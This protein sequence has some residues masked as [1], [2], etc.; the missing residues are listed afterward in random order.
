M[1]EAEKKPGGS[2][3]STAKSTGRKTPQSGR[4]SPGKKSTGKKT[5]TGKTPE[6][7]QEATD[8]NTQFN[9]TYYKV[10]VTRQHNLSAVYYNILYFYTFQQFDIF[11]N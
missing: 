10:A 4:S 2:R 3:K 7:T 8:G 11:Y 9:R 5:P 1:D 6:P